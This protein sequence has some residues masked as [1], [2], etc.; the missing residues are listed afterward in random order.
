MSFMGSYRISNHLQSI[1]YENNRPPAWTMK[2]RPVRYDDHEEAGEFIFKTICPNKNPIKAS[3]EKFS[4]SDL[5]RLKT[6]NDSFHTRCTYRSVSPKCS[7]GSSFLFKHWRFFAENKWKHFHKDLRP[8]FSKIKDELLNYD[9]IP[10]R[11][12]HDNKDFERNFDDS[13][14]KENCSRF[15]SISISGAQENRDVIHQDYGKGCLSD[16]NFGNYLPWCQNADNLFQSLKF[17]RNCSVPP[18]LRN[19]FDLSSKKRR[20]N[21]KSPR[22]CLLSESSRQRLFGIHKNNSNCLNEAYSDNQDWT[23]ASFWTQWNRI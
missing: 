18:I 7:I 2:L 21:D 10:R 4:K 9:I 13:Q 16:N 6:R 1:S 5:K 17:L 3:S 20:H 11:A 22:N 12:L 14:R 19:A 15:R 8:Q 23:T